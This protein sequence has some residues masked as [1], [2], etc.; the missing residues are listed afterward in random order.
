MHASQVLR[1][2]GLPKWHW[3]SA[4]NK[5]PLTARTNR[6]I[7]GKAPSKYLAPI[8]AELGAS[9]VDAILETHLIDPAHLRADDF[10]AFLRHRAAALL[11][12]I[13]T[14]MGKAVQGRDAEETVEAFGAPLTPLVS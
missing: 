8:D 5:A 7:G 12:R 3:N 9:K 1:L 10:D 11:D 6:A 2:F 13:E 4:V 14:A